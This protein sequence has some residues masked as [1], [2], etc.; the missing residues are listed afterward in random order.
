MS[1]QFKLMILANVVLAASFLICNYVYFYFI[2]RFDGHAALW[3]PLWLTFTNV[4]E[5]R[6]VGHTIGVPE[7]N[8]S[9]YFFWVLMAA[10]VY[11]LFRQ[12]KISDLKQ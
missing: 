6:T 3:S 11:F 7:P 8:F 12:Q 9:F 4:D 10:N 1:K 5:I 2:N